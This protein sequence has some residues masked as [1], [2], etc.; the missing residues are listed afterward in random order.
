MLMLDVIF[1]LFAEVLHESAYRHRR[2]IAQGAN[3]AA[4]YVVGH[5][6]EQVQVARAALAEAEVVADQQVAKQSPQSDPSRLL[7]G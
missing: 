7:S 3:G 5:R 1:K 2:R 4:L 6:V